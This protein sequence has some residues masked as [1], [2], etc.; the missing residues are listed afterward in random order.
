MRGPVILPLKRMRR[1]PG[2]IIFP[3]SLRICV[4][5]QAGSHIGDALLVFAGLRICAVLDIYRPDY[6]N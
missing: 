6:Y 1:C 5:M 3:D 4:S 2:N